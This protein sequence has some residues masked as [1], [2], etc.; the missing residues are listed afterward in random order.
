MVAAARAGEYA[1]AEGIS[2]LDAKHLLM[3]SYCIN[4]VFYLLLK[5]EGKP[6]R[7]H[8]VVLRL[9]E[10]R[11]YLE[12][13]RP[14]DRK[15]QYQIDKLLKMADEGAAAGDG[16]EPTD[17]PLQF[18]PNPDALVSKVDEDAEEGGG[19]GVYRPPKMLPTAMDDFEEG[20]KSAKEKR[21]EKEARRRASR[22]ALIKVRRDAVASIISLAASLSFRS[23]HLVGVRLARVWPPP[24]PAPPLASSFFGHFRRCAAPWRMKAT[25]YLAAESTR[26]KSWAGYRSNT[27]SG[28]PN[29]ELDI[30]LPLV[31]IRFTTTVPLGDAALDLAP[32][33]PS[34]THEPHAPLLPPPGNDRSSRRNS[35]RHPRSSAATTATPRVPLR[36][37]SLPAWKPARRLRRIFSRA[38]PL[39]KTERRRA[40]ATTRSMNALAQVGDFGDDVA[41][42][43]EVA[44][45]LEGRKR[46]RLVDAAS[47]G[48]GAAAKAAEPAAN[49][50]CR[51]AILSGYDVHSRATN[52]TT[53]TGVS[54]TDSTRRVLV[55]LSHHSKRR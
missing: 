47:A 45:E 30:H 7:D 39:S 51:C 25:F 16:A 23:N 17:D 2:Y 19:E 53:T 8:P 9:V 6:V 15:L 12:K 28:V 14:I 32:T 38:V 13:L 22:S 43:V 49:R 55:S 24:A 40:K 20:G 5:A 4:I 31:S 36:S 54:T 27:M 1:T 26:T 46:Q 34:P 3:L 41:D 50:T 33:R 18:R 11:T 35:A 42:L 21:K 29:Q 44:E 52:P 10:I 37:A 48:P